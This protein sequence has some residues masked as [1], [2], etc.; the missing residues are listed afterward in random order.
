MSENYQRRNP[1][2]QDQLKRVTVFLDVQLLQE[3]SA[4][5]I[6]KDNHS[7]GVSCRAPTG[8]RKGMGG[9]GGAKRL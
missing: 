4:L 8:N 7:T 6:S 9:G 1:E 3:A 2:S 5:V